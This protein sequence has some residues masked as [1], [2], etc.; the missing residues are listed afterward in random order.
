MSRRKHLVAIVPAMS[1]ADT[2][3][4]VILELKKLNPDEIIVVNNGSVDR[5]GDI[6][7]E[8]GVTVLEYEQAL[9]NDI[10]R[11]LGALHTEADIY[12][13]TDSDIVIPAKDLRPFVEDIEAGAD[14]SI[15]AIEWCAR[16]PTPDTPSVARYFLNL[17]L[18]RRDLGLE[19]CLTIPHA[20]SH[21]AL[22]QIGKEVLSNPLLAT[23]MVIDEGLTVTVPTEYNV[24][25]KNK[26]RTAHKTLPG[27]ILPTAYTR[28]HG[29][30]IEA[31]WYFLTRKGP[32]GGYGQGMRNRKAFYEVQRESLGDIGK[33]GNSNVTVVLSVSHRSTSLSHLLGA[34]VDMP[35]NVIPVLHGADARTVHMFRDLGWTCVSLP[36]YVGHE[37]AFAIGASFAQTDYVVFHDTMLPIDAYE[38]D[39]MVAPLQQQQANFVLNNQSR[40]FGK[41]EG[42]SMVHIGAY[43]MNVAALRPELMTSTMLLPPYAMDRKA[44]N[45]VPPAALMSPCLAQMLGYDRDLK[46]VNGPSIDYEGRLNVRYHPFLLDEER[47]MGDFMEGLWYQIL[48]FGY[49]GGFHDGKRIRSALQ[50]DTPT[51]PLT[52]PR[53][54]P[55]V[56]IDD[57][58]LLV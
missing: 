26:P 51:F 40:R 31:F 39:Q 49:R 18:R 14:H 21:R 10:P 1:E 24:L 11:A 33:N 52:L 36:H 32:R 47:M 42:M 56:S 29:D 13:F 3:G 41:L 54:N 7:R 57:I 37:V 44:L 35:V 12:L 27:Q 23:A 2:I 58:I 19:N 22:M 28:I 16:Y 8:M 43:F 38:L 50:H 6:A 20:F 17:F 9:G 25:G 15:N 4:P 30:T 46:V 48:R 5:T 53:E 45:E 55:S 34:L